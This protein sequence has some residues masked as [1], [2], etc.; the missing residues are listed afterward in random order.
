MDFVKVYSCPNCNTNLKIDLKDYIT[1]VSTYERQ[2]GSE[3]EHTIECEDTCSNCN[4]EFI[5]SG[6]IWEYPEGTENLDDTK[7]SLSV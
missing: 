2:M 5:I 4:S 1:D 3:F 7:I 6:S